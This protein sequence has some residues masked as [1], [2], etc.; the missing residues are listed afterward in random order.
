MILS[1]EEQ[2][3]FFQNYL[4]LLYY[5]GAYEGLLLQSATM[6]DFFYTDLNTKAKCR[7][8]LFS[9]A[10]AIKFYKEDNRK[11]LGN[12]SKLAFV[13]NVAQG[14][15]G[16]FVFLKE[17]KSSA[18]FQ[19]IESEKFYEVTGITEPISKLAPGYPAVIET[20]IFNFSG[21]IICDGLVLNNATLEP[22]IIKDVMAIYKECQEMKTVLKII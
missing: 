20:A 14:I 8:V 7:S 2:D 10:D 18:V 9:D 13:N 19:H 6:Q 17:T 21:K 3:D 22:S 4:P 15:F 12:E 16:K 11:Y 5:A 1:K